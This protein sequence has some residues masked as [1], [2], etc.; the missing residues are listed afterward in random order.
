MY[1]KALFDF[2]PSKNMQIFDQANSGKASVAK[3]IDHTL[4]KSDATSVEIAKICKE[5]MQYGFASVCVNPIYVKLAV[6]L[7]KNT[8]VNV[9]T[10]I[11]FPLGTTFSIVKK[12][13]AEKALSEGA[14]ELDMVMAI[15]ALKEKNFA[16]VA[17]EIS[18][19]AAIAHQSRAILKVII[20][21]ALLT[22]DEKMIACRL[23]AENGGDFVKTSTGFAKSGATVNDI[24]LL[25]A[26]CKDRLKIKA[27]GGIRTFEQALSMIEAGADRLGTSS[28]VAICS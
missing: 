25:K 21:T 11:G 16:L 15:G 22:D 23:I 13:E 27:S 20:E 28:G 24:K 4:L 2:L 19:L 1:I 17:S 5:A 3:L 9:C 12:V 8:P 26:Y 6:K 14:K 18:E 10:V 7:L